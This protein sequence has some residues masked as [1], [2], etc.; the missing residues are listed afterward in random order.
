MPFFFALCLFCF[1]AVLTMLFSVFSLVLEKRRM[2]VKYLRIDSCRGL[3]YLVP[4]WIYNAACTAELLML[5]VTILLAFRISHYDKIT[6][7]LFIILIAMA[8]AAI[9]DEF[10]GQDISGSME[11]VEREDNLKGEMRNV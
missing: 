1:L 9:L 4:R 3:L 7:D 11:R 5:G 10:H 2:Y 8:L 6:G